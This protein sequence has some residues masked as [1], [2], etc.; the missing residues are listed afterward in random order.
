MKAMALYM[1]LLNETLLWA[2]TRNFYTFLDEKSID[3]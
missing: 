1:D 2:R 3:A